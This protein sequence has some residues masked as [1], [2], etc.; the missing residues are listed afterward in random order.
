[1]SMLDI[2]FAATSQ[3]RP[4]LAALA[5]L[6]AGA[7][8][9][10]LVSL[11][12]DDLE[13]QTAAAETRLRSLTRRG[14]PAAAG[15]PAPGATP[16][17]EALARLQAPWPDLLEQLEA[18]T[19]L[20]VAVLDVDA[21]ARGRTLRLAGEAKTMD[22]VLAFIERLRQSRRLNEVYLQSHEARKVGAVEVIAFTVQA[23]WP[24]TRDAARDVVQ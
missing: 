22:D 19:D 14:P 12:L 13:Q 6:L 16:A 3:R 10:A 18:I 4:N 9:L 23:T 2:D 15:K 24:M 20:P 11:E 7:A 5:L 17:S 1:M 8:T 21:E